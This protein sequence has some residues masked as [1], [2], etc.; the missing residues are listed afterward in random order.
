M[1]RREWL[2]FSLLATGGLRPSLAIADEP[3]PAKSADEMIHNYLAAEVKRLR[4]AGLTFR[5]DIITGP[6]GSQ[7]I[8]DDPFGNPIELF[9]PAEK[10]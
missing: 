8:L 3:A 6:G 2:Q 9:Q 5:N 1:T 7:I 10:R 4:G